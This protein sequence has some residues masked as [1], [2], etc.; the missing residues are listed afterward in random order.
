MP[1][2]YLPKNEA[3]LE[4]WLENFSNV[5]STHVQELG[6]TS[7]QVIEI[8][9]NYTLVSSSL[10][11]VETS[12]QATRGKVTAKDNNIKRVV[13]RTRSI[14][15]QIQ[16]KAD[17]PEELKRQLGI[18]VRDTPATKTPPDIPTGVKV[19]TNSNGK[20]TVTWE[21]GGN[22]PTTTFLIEATVDDTTPFV[23]V[24]TVTSTKFVHSNQTP[25]ARIYYR[26][27]A[28]RHGVLSGASASVVAYGPSGRNQLQ[29]A[30]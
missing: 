14:V 7:A 21:R 16:G 23:V 4:G 17:V 13:A 15:R 9:E 8:G 2:G 30:A 6:L 3:K 22:M 20:N 1:D 10:A 18:T 11:D 29:A 19:T 26:V 5:V 27:R 28:A 12:K 24:G 25:G